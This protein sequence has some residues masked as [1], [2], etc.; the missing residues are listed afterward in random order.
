MT[1]AEFMITYEATLV[2]MYDWAKSD[3]TKRARFMASV[4]TT[5]GVPG[6][7]SLHTWHADGEA[8]RKAWRD[9]GGNGVPSL[10]KLRALA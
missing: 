3:L 6:V 5:I 7:H 4:A 2:S 1:K 9:I 10:K 8:L